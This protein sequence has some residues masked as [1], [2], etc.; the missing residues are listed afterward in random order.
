M[1]LFSIDVE[2]KVKLVCANSQGLGKHEDPLL[3]QQAEA[4]VGKWMKLIKSSPEEKEAKDNKEREKELKDKDREKRKERK[5]REK[6]RG[7]KEK[8]RRHDDDK[9]KVC[10]CLSIIH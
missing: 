2:L 8:S 5:D 7:D 10:I 1:R 3:A 4:L 9:K 6:D